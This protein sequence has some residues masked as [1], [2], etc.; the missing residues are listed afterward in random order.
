MNGTCHLSNFIQAQNLRIRVILDWRYL[1]L[2]SSRNRTL[3]PS[4]RRNDTRL[5]F[6]SNRKLHQK[7]KISNICP[8]TLR[9][10]SRISLS[11]EKILAS[12]YVN[13]TACGFITELLWFGNSHGV[14]PL[15]LAQQFERS[16]FHECIR[17]SIFTQCFCSS[18]R[19]L[20]LFL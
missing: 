17:S 13:A 2:L 15:I 7:P 10:R 20:T 19:S 6:V 14:N 5:L 11:S 16:L 8:E 3:Q 4:A 1:L 12:A 18:P 9:T